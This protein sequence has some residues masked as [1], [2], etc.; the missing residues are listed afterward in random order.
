[1]SG[2]SGPEGTMNHRQRVINRAARR[3]L[4]QDGL[5]RGVWC[6]AGAGAAVVGLV[7]AERVFGAPIPWATVA[8]ALPAGTAAA[9]GLWTWFARRSPQRV[10][11]AIDEAAGLRE[12]LSTSL[13]LEHNSDAWSTAVVEASEERAKV[14]NV[15]QALPLGAPR[16]WP[17][18][19]GSAL[20]ALIAFLAVPDLDLFGKASTREGRE[21]EESELRLVR[22]TLKP[23]QEKLEEL[24]KKAG[25][26][27]GAA[28]A[29]E[30]PEVAEAKTPEDARRAIVKE[31]SSIAKQ[32]QEQGAGDQA[33]RQEALADAM[34]ELRSP[35][36]GELS[37]TA[38]KLA[39][40]DFRS[41]QKALQEIQQKLQSG[42]LTEDERKK[43]EQQASNLSQQLS[44]LSED[45]KP[46]GEQM[47]QAL[48][49][50]GMSAEQAQQLAEQMQ[51][52]P[53]A[54]QEMM[55]QAMQQMQNMSPEQRQ[56][57]Q[58]MAA[59]MQASQQMRELAQQMQQMA[60]GMKNNDATC[61][62]GACNSMGDLAGQQSQ[63][64]ASQQSMEQAMAQ[65]EK[66]MA[67]ANQGRAGDQPGPAGTQPWSAGESQAQGNG[68]GGPGRGNGPSTGDTPA[69]TRTKREI[70][71]SQDSGKGP[72]IASEVMEGESDVGESHAE[73]VE[74][75]EAADAA[76][77]EALE[78]QL[79]PRNRQELVKRYF[80]TMKRRTGPKDE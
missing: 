24:L 39:R 29:L 31:L 13:A 49:Q 68:S 25:I 21:R 6:V 33:Q 32:L 45:H 20:A 36:E 62:D 7:A 58:Q 30:T 12:A 42:E 4:V 55:R 61:A 9:A 47:A 71:K 18:A 57:L 77:S 59:Q 74:A 38:R 40:G 46:S 67:Q 22:E 8:W 35:G 2:V 41:A 28:D 53:A 60:D 17:V 15:R 11:L 48:Q 64:E 50:G 43:L 16:A 1:M 79:V 63:G 69:P 27:P 37:E 80:S 72:V 3:L 78:T 14:V 19:A 65:L 52:N 73:F 76:A 66:M 75:V 5:F 51:S 34:R 26:E 23:E 54:A 70:A 10:A 56:Q 44:K